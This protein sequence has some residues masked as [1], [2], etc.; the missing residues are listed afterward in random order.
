MKRFSLTAQPSWKTFA[1]IALGSV[2]NERQDYA[3][4]GENMRL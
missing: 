1:P 2:A 4:S 3:L